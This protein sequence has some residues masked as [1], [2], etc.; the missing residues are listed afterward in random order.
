MTTNNELHEGDLVRVIDGEHRGMYGKLLTFKLRKGFI[1]YHPI[2]L[3]EIPGIGMR[4]YLRDE[5]ESY[6]AIDPIGTLKYGYEEWVR[7]LPP[8][9][10]PPDE[11]ER[12]TEE[13]RGVV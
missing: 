13:S 6:G 11:I 5:L 2:C 10:A 8:M 7:G 9:P 1:Y 12:V 4:I 3:V